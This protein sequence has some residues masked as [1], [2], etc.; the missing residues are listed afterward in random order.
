MRLAAQSFLQFD[1]IREGVIV[2]KN[3]AL[4]GILMVSSV[5][6]ELKSAE[7]QD[8]IIFQ[9]QNFLNSLDFSC[10]IIIQSRRLNITG[11]FEKLKELE[12]GQKNE[13][14]KIQTIE[15]RKFVEKLV[16]KGTI[17]TKQFFVVVPYTIGEMRGIKSTTPFK[18]GV[19]MALTEEVFQRC[20]DQLYQRMEFVGIGLRRSGLGVVPLTTPELIELLWGW[21]HPKES[22]VGY[23]P[24]IL[25]EFMK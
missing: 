25:P 15:Y 18:K 7:E 5:N 23:Y 4:R 3:K 13:L 11:Y 19:S 10:Q 21:H 14:L 8:A 20:R 24:E 12:R 9:F 2:L 16:A 1:Q 22:E 6:F 17:M